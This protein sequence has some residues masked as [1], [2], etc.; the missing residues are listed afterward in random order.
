MYY[1]KDVKEYGNKVVDVQ[2]WKCWEEMRNFK[3]VFQVR[4]QEFESLWSNILFLITCFSKL[5]KQE[6]SWGICLVTR[7]NVMQVSYL[8]DGDE[9]SPSCKEPSG[10]ACLRFGCPTWWKMRWRSGSQE[11]RYSPGFATNSQ[12]DL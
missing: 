4:H 1:S 12:H 6:G 11:P 10:L 5:Q 9:R 8:P 7:A 3:A 2:S